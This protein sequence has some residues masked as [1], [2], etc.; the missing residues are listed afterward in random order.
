MKARKSYTRNDTDHLVA[1]L[2]E[3]QSM[4]VAYRRGVAT[5]G[6]LKVGDHFVNAK[7][8][9]VKLGYASHSMEHHL[10]VEGF[11]DAMQDQGVYVLTNPANLICAFSTQPE[12][13]TVAH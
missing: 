4:S 7:Q 3:Q 10:F 5:F 13:Q 8:E 6:R 2:L 9:A 12:R 11:M 1:Q